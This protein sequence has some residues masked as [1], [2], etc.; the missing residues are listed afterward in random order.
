MSRSP[1]GKVMQQKAAGSR[2]SDS[3]DVSRS[4]SGQPEKRSHPLSRWEWREVTPRTRPGYC[5]PYAGDDLWL[6]LP[7]GCVHQWGRSKLYTRGVVGS[8][9]RWP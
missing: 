7:G 3:V 1:L 9:S 4:R 5:R 8:D 6:A 2:Q